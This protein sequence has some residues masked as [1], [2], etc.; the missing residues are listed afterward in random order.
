VTA[1]QDTVSSNYLF[2]A[3]ALD[4]SAWLLPQVALC[5]SSNC[6]RDGKGAA[7]QQPAICWISVC[8]GWLV[9]PV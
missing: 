6:R 4:N 2:D 7:P 1:A 9:A 8:A 3:S 5:D